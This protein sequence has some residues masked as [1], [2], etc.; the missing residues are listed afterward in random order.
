V[1]RRKGL[2]PLIGAIA[3]V[4][5]FAAHAPAASGA[6]ALNEVNCEGTDW[7]ELVNTSE[8]PADVSGWL[9]TDDPLDSTRDDHRMLFAAG[10][11]IAA[12]G[13]LVVERGAAG[14]PFGISC[15]GDTLRLADGAGA[16]ADEIAVPTL[17]SAG[18]TW[19][20]YPN[21]TGDWEETI[22]TQSSPNELSTAGPGAPDPAAWMFDPAN[23]VE[24]DLTA[25]PESIAAMNAAAPN[26]PGDHVIASFSLTT[27][28]GTYG[29]LTVGIRLKGTG[30]F[31]PLS[32]KAAFKVKFNE[33]VPGQRFLGLKR[34]TLNNMVQDP[35]MVHEVLSYELFR[36]AGL[37]AP[38]TGYAYVSLNDE[39][40]GLYLNLETYDDSTLP[41]MFAG[42]T[43][44]YEGERAA[45]VRP[46]GA[47][48]F[49]VDEGSEAD[50]SDLEALIAAAHAPGDFAQNLEA[51]ADIQQMIRMWA[52][53]KYI[54]HHDGYAGEPFGERPNNY[55]LHSS[56]S[57]RFS[58]L[59]FGTDQT[60]GFQ[61]PF[62]ERTAG[63][64]W[65][66]C[67]A[68]PSCFDLYRNAVSQVR[69]NALGLDL[70]GLA[71]ATA[72]SLGPWQA[73]DPRKEQT[74]AEIAAAVEATRGFIAARPGEAAAWLAY[75]ALT[76]P[77]WAA[78]AL[79]PGASPAP[80]RARPRARK[81]CRKPKRRGCRRR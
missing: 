71:L 81:P 74:T 63:L 27:T 6:V 38:R 14:F 12:H 54:G 5:A 45:D 31:R 33:F 58:M 62:G 67:A 8:A 51:T 48:A 3:A 35:S 52:V 75:P 39:P 50:R 18:D 26:D 68:D 56:P 57:G 72:E 64:L 32:G 20:R 78:P 55:Y 13:D 22:P 61:L 10:T 15:G 79:V 16:L 9:L 34:L 59:P 42:T 43:H 21:G 23:V 80:P 36:A 77:P 49:E 19:G 25:P 4:A 44:L 47:G 53:E 66:R 17:V 1:N 76:E 69:A 73:L 24:I 30:S 28:G 2:R 46:G 41:R 65:N 29:P 60:W 11:I 7:V 40:Y 37:P 70:D